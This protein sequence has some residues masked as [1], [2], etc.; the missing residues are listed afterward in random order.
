MN[1]ISPLRCTLVID[2]NILLKRNLH[3]SGVLNR[4]QAGR[5]RPKRKQ[6]QPLTYEMANPPHFIVAR[7]S[8]NS[9]NTSNVQDGNRPAETALEDI[10]I[11]R[12]ITGTWHGLFVSEIIIKRQHNLI[13]IAGIVVRRVSP[14]KMYFLIGYSEALLSYWLHCPVK[15]EIVTTQD[16]EDVIYKVI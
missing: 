13:R 8:W 12:F 7:K 5:Y 1:L 11:R 10:F 9:W 6:P 14:G 2:S 15:M 3:I 16:K 4:T